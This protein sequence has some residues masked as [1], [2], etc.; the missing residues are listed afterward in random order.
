MSAHLRLPIVWP[1]CEVVPAPF[2][3]DV[4]PVPPETSLRESELHASLS[5]SDPR[6]AVLVDRA[7]MSRLD[8]PPARHFSHSLPSANTP[9]GF[10]QLDV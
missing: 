9:L 10:V 3:G 7:P 8:G 2:D 4:L 6:R 1:H 5:R